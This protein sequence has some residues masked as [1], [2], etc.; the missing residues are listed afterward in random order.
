M[1]TLDDYFCSIIPDG[2]ARRRTAVKRTTLNASP[3][4]D[5][6]KIGPTG[7]Y[8]VGTAEV[9]CIEWRRTRRRVGHGSPTPM[10]IGNLFVSSNPENAE[11]ES[12]Q[13]VLAEEYEELVL[14]IKQWT[15]EGDDGIFRSR[16]FAKPI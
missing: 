6:R 16:D 5:E 4:H 10:D 2:L 14:L 1:A 15:I 7:Q 3:I 11:D 9:P 8:A 13:K 12:R